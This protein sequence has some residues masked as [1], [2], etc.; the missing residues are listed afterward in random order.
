MRALASAIAAKHDRTLESTIFGTSNPDNVAALLATFVGGHLGIVDGVHFYR[1]G[2]GLVAGVHVVGIGDIVVKIHRRN[3]GEARLRASQRVQLHLADSGFPAPRPVLAPT[4]IADGIATAETMICGEPVDGHDPA[5][6]SETAAC[7]QR[8]I[9]VATPASQADLSGSDLMTP[10]RRSGLW[11]DPHDVRFDFGATAAGA[12]WIDRLAA[13]AQ[14]RLRTTTAAEVVAH[15]DWR[16][17]NLALRDGT[18]VGVYDWDSVGR[19]PEAVAVGQSSAQFSTD[20]IIGHSTLPTTEEMEAFVAD[21]EVA[22]GHGFTNEERAVV[23]AANLMVL[24]YCARC[25]HSDRLLRPELVSSEN[26]WA[27]LLRLRRA[28]P[29]GW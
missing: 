21:Y 27:E 26:T 18:I 9:S 13:E 7:L 20:W 22:R 4:L 5:V 6:R 23:E 8:F 1:G 2:T 12:E 15:F 14:Q 11:G 29:L 19:A 24:A 28:H 17:E 25:E 10:T 16:V 3:A